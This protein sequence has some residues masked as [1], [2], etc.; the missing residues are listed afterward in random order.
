MVALG[1]VT[2]VPEVKSCQGPD[3]CY[4]CKGWFTDSHMR[5]YL[6]KLTVMMPYNRNVSEPRVTHR[7]Q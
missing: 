6:G 2:G 7:E 4:W 1:E 5:R 3:G